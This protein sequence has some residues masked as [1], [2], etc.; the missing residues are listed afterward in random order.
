MK[1]NGPLNGTFLGSISEDGNFKL[2]QEDAAQAPKSGRRF[3]CIMSLASKTRLPWVSLDFKNV[4]TDTFLA[5]ITYDGNFTILEPRNHENLAGEWSDWMEG[6]DFWAC[7]PIPHRSEETAFKVV[8]HQDALPC[9]TALAA[10][11]D[12]KA[13]SIA[14]SVMNT[15]KIY[16]SN[17]QKQLHLA[18]ELTGATDLVRDVAWAEGS[19]RGFDLLATASKDEHVRVYEIHTYAAEEQDVQPGRRGSLRSVDDRRQSVSKPKA[20][21]PSGIGAKL[22]GI[23]RTDSHGG[24]VVPTGPGR[25]RHQVKLVDTIYEG[26]AEEDTLAMW[27]VQFDDDGMS[28]TE[29]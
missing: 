3:K 13:L 20:K 23:T 26:G 24:P 15:I 22:A 2:W 16:R 7:D 1:W 25:L 19:V 27:R 9:Y 28:D 6:Q 21:V 17:G 14:V 4:G 5:L 12:S 8:F 10:G 18:A 29:V 11:L